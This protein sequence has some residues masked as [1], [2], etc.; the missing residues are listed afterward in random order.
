[1]AAHISFKLWKHINIKIV[2]SLKRFTD[3]NVCFEKVMG[4]N[5]EIFAAAVKF[6]VEKFRWR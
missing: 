3:R 2:H 5:V 6:E 1:M 4:N